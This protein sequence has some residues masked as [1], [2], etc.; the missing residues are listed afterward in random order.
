MKKMQRLTKSAIYRT[1]LSAIS[2]PSFQLKRQSP[3]V[4]CQTVGSIFG[5]LSPNLTSNIRAYGC[6]VDSC[7]RSSHNQGGEGNQLFSFEHIVSRVLAQHK[8]PSLQTLC[9][10]YDFCSNCYSLGMWI[11]NVTFRKV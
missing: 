10:T 1:L 8:A 7:V 3:Q 4:S 6:S 5:L 2:S 9:L 11:D